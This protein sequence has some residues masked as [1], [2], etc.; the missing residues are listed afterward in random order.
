MLL[1]ITTTHQPATDL[2]YL[3]H[4]HPDKLQ[5]FNLSFGQAQ[6]FYPEATDTI[7]TVALMLDVNAVE[8]VRGKAGSQPQTLGDYV[9]DRPYVA[10]SFLSVAISQVFRSAMCG[11]CRDRP[12]LANIPIPLTVRIPVLPSR[13]RESFVRDLFAP[14]GYEIQLERLPLDQHFTHWGNSSYFDLTLN[15]TIRLQDLLG[16]LYVLIPVLDDHKHYFVNEE[17]VAKLLRHG[18]GWLTTHPLREEIANRY[19]KRQRSLTRSALAQI[20]PEEVEIVE[21][22]ETTEPTIAPVSLNEQ[23]LQTVVAVLKE[24]GAKRVVDLGCGEGKLVAEPQFSEILGMDVTYRSI[25]IAQTRVLARL[26]IDQQQRLQIIQGSLTYRDDRLA[27]YDAATVIEVIEHM[28]IDRLATFERVLFDCARP[29]L[30]I[31]TTPNI[32]YNV[33][34]P[35]LAAGKLRHVDHRFEWT[36]TEFE[37]W[38]KTVQDNYSYSVEFRPIGDGD[39][40]VGSPTQMAVFTA[41]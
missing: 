7:C 1:T 14:L 21:I 3:L 38:G 33:N 2:G 23:R 36:R 32:E 15:H 19:L 6:V 13:G 10:S 30:V 9:S 18:A 25:E 5:T 27:G 26:L 4:K 40:A 12:E 28:D 29:Q 22:D 16:H 39:S 11:Q 17:E 20:A 41:K 24:Y 34:Y 8:L 31:V 35:N 37:N